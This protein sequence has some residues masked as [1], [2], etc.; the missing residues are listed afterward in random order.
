MSQHFY[1]K[2]NREVSVYRDGDMIV[3]AIDNQT[4]YCTTTQEVREWLQIHGVV[5]E[6]PFFGSCNSEKIIE[7]L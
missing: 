4:N 7:N 6:G 5:R 2:D 3:V 1:T